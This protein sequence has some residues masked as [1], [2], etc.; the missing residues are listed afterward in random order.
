MN[1]ACHR[2]AGRVDAVDAAGGEQVA[3][4]HVLGGRHVAQLHHAAARRRI[5]IGHAARA[6]ARVHHRNH[7]IAIDQQRDLADKRVDARD[8]A[9]HAR[10]VHHRRAG[11]DALHLPLADDHAAAVGVGG[12]VQHLRRHGGH[13]HAFTQRQQL[14]QAV[15][16]QLQLLDLAGALRLLGQL[17][18]RR[19]F[20]GARGLQVGQVADAGL[21]PLHRLQRQPL[22]RVQHGGDHRAQRL[23][24]VKARIGHHQEQRQRAQQHQPRQRRR[25]LLEKGRRRAVKRFERHGGSAVRHGRIYYQNESIV[26]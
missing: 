9:Q 10:F 26:R 15:V 18:A 24:D 8:L 7:L 14:A 11:L 2:Q 23:H 25:P 5:A 17:D 1:H 19:F 12:V 3:L 22:R 6:G 20:G 21:H 13:L 4:L 16:F